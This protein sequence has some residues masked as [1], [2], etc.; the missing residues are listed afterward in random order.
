MRS[1]L[2]RIHT[3]LGA[4]P[5]AC[6]SVVLLVVSSST[7]TNKKVIT[8]HARPTRASAA[9]PLHTGVNI[10]TSDCFLSTPPPEHNTARV[11]RGLLYVQPQQSAV[12]AS[13]DRRSAHP[14]VLH[15]WRHHRALHIRHCHIRRWPHAHRMWL[16]CATTSPPLLNASP[17]CKPHF[18]VHHRPQCHA[19]PSERRLLIKA[20][21]S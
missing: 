18:C 17:A 13:G 9:A 10:S 16:R 15:V 6:V 19:S 2:S 4:S 8:C 14:G 11:C 20:D 3:H 12:R 1:C 21:W 7:K 5:R